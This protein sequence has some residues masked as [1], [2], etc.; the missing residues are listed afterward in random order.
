MEGGGPLH[1]H[2]IVI[3]TSPERMTINN[4]DVII[5]LV[6][7]KPR[8]KQTNVL[9]FLSDSFPNYNQTIMKQDT[10]RSLDASQTAADQVEELRAKIHLKGTVEAPLTD[11]ADIFFYLFEFNI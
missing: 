8:N 4:C 5:V 1:F 7:W 11:F 2:I 9:F 10:M 6:P 3:V